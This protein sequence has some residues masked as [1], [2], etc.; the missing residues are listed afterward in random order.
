MT[1]SGS[2]QSTFTSPAADVGTAVGAV[3]DPKMKSSTTG[4]V[5][6]GVEPKSQ[7]MPKPLSLV[8]SLMMLLSRFVPV[9]GPTCSAARLLSP[10][11]TSA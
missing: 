7:L 10:K 5:V 1:P 3:T 11:T 8:G 6:P 2:V 4:E 9:P